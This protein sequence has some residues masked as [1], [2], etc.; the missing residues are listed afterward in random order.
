MLEIYYLERKKKSEFF[1]LLFESEQ[2]KLGKQ[3]KVYHAITS[4]SFFS[5]FFTS[6]EAWLMEGKLNLKDMK[7][8]ILKI[9]MKRTLMRRKQNAIKGSTWALT[10]L[11]SK[12]FIISCC[13]WN[14]TPINCL[15]NWKISI[16][17]Q[18]RGT[19]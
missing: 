5:L 19:N 14:Y 2:T 18:W 9:L 10:R 1:F 4:E 17:V 15:I 13:S 6:F 16:A 11:T 7:W 8:E 12:Q 3:K